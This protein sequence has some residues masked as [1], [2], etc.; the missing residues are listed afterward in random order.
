M[1]AKPFIDPADFAPGYMRRGARR[2][3]KQGDREP[4]INIQNYYVEKKLLP[5]SSFD[6]G[7]L[8]FDNPIC[9]RHQLRT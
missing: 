6:D 7:A 3:P 8:Q 1:A 2:L 5:K 9:A 4:W